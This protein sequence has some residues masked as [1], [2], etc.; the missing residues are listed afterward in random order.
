MTVKCFTS[1]EKDRIVADYIGKCFPNNKALAECWATSTRTINRILEERGLATPVPRLKGEAHQ[2]MLLLK[3][4]GIST[5]KELAEILV[6]YMNS[7]PPARPIAISQSAKQPR[8]FQ[9]I[10]NPA[11][12]HRFPLAA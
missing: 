3:D 2:V 12:D 6:Q 1:L 11:D 9:P 10:T 4:H 5:A 8:L 7:T